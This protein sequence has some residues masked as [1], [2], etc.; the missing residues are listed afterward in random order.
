MPA[1]VFW[2]SLLVTLWVYMGYPLLLIVWRAIRRRPVRKIYQ[3]PTVSIVLAMHNESHTVQ[4]KMLNCFALDY[5]ADK[6]QIIVSLDAPSDNTEDLLEP[7]EQRGV[8][9]VRSN[10]RKGKA[11]AIN[12]AM[13]FASGEIVL[14]GDARQRLSENA[15]RELVANFSDPAVGAVSGELVL[16]D[17]NGEESKE[18][19]G[20]YWR[21]EKALRAMESEISSVPGSTGA[22]YAIRRNLFQPLPQGT[23]LDDVLIPM[24]IVLNGKRAIFEPAAR[25]Y[26]QVTLTPE[27]EFEK[28]RR[29]LMGNYE[30]LFQAPELLLPG[31]NPILVQF[32]SHKVGRLIVPW[33][34]VALLM[35]NLFLLHGF[36]LLFLIAQVLFYTFALAGG[37][38]SRRKEDLKVQA[39]SLRK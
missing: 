24:R 36:Y 1:H 8:K 15:L 34:L 5:P 3:E 9:V 37:V 28:K 38:M 21:Y 11:A 32:F 4:A 10:V 23:I 29:T 16:L 14:F 13:P 12:A 6:L 35:S 33:C 25:A 39:C 30:L 31:R 20:L 7:W 19:V 22:I 26:D 27:L 2:I 18:G 17:Q